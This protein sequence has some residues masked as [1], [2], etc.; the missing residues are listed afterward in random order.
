MSARAVYY[1]PIALAD[2]R[3]VH[4]F[5]SAK[6]PLA[7]ERAIDAI[8][9]AVRLLLDFPES[10]RRRTD[11][12]AAHRELIIPFGSSGYVVLYGID[13]AGIIVLSIRHQREAGY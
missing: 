8:R 6:S 13:T 7:A 10:G 4:R 3:R 5:L 9:L 1:T 11:G 2:L 12:D